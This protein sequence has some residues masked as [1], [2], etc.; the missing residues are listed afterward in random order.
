LGAFGQ[1][2]PQ[3]HPNLF[4]QNLSDGG[5]GNMFGVHRLDQL[6]YGNGDKYEGQVLRDKRDGQDKR[7]G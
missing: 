1:P 5:A 6:T 2:I 7:D 4:N 3:G